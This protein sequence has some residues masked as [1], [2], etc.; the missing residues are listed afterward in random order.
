VLHADE[1]NSALSEKLGYDVYH[2]HLH[3]VYV[4]VVE[5][6]VLW[7]KRCKDPALV[8]TVKEVIPQISHSKKW[9]KIKTADE[10]GK[11]RFVNSYSFLQD[12]YFEHMKSAGFDGFERGERGSTAEHLD[13][14]DYK[15]QQDEKRLDVLDTRIEK[16]Q[17]KIEKLDKSIAVKS[18]AKST[19]DEINA[20]GKPALLG[21]VNFSDDEAK[22]LK[23]LARQTIK[24]D[25]R[26][27]KLKRE[28]DALQVE[29]DKTKTQLQDAKIEA[30]HWHREYTTLLSEV[31]DF[32]TA[33]RKFPQRLREFISEL[34]RPEREEQER[35]EAER[36]AQ[37]SERK[38][39]RK[40]YDI[41]GR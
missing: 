17:E 3:V 38:Q 22:R 19:L 15:I 21:G 10:K 13:V 40:S 20:M 2:Y 41:G 30:N 9:P 6:E 29:L 8:G 26:M 25:E 23:S 27:A 37:I 31:K 18:N 24:S 16:R 11:T 33:I 12:R 32:I 1:R 39:Q 4:P 34:F 5:K 35:R 36:Q 28:M 14:L 7:S